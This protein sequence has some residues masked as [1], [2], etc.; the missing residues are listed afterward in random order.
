MTDGYKRLDQNG[1]CELAVAEFGEICRSF[2]TEHN[3]VSAYIRVGVVLAAGF[4]DQSKAVPQNKLIGDVG[5]HRFQDADPPE[6]TR[7]GRSPP[8]FRAGRSHVTRRP[9]ASPFEP[10]CDPPFGGSPK[11]RDST[12]LCARRNDRPGRF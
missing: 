10:P 4:H 7:A 12:I 9:F 6:G 11:G 5:R 2:V 8:R 3:F 1:E